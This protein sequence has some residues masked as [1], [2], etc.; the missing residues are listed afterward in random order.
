[1]RPDGN[2]GP[3]PFGTLLGTAPGGVAAYSSDYDSADERLLPNRS[4]F[5][6]YRDGIYMG[7]KWQCVEFA[8]RWM[9][10]N[11]GWIFDDVA[12]NKSMLLSPKSYRRLILPQVRR[13]VRA[14]QEAGAR[15]IGYHSDGNISSIL[16]GLV[17]AGITILNPIEPRA[18]M[19]VVDLRK[20]YGKKLTFVGGLC[21]TLVLP[22]GTREEVERHVEHVL[23]AD[24]GG[25]LIIGSHSISNEV[26][27][28]R[29]EFMMSI[30]EKHGRPSPGF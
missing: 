4:A 18:R 12:S 30:L 21:N 28:D 22:T 27:V 19:D 8:R 14:F 7:Y 15:Y 17:D 29:Y 2:A 24:D 16:D 10:L 3:E 11:K 1:M 9:Y 13:M 20:R 26:S 6:S 23:S 5:R 25:G